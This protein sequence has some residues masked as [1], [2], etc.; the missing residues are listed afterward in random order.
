MKP[1]LQRA[2]EAGRQAQRDGR[3][4]YVSIDPVGRELMEEAQNTGS[5]MVARVVTEWRNAYYLEGQKC[6]STK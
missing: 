5:K 1:L 4:E 3:P 6:N 2:V